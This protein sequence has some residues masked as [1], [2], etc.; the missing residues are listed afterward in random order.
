MSAAS[1]YNRVAGAPISWG[2]SE[3]PGWGTQL[4]PDRVLAEMR[5][6]GLRFVEAGPA[7]YLG[8][9]AAAVRSLLEE[10]GLS[11]VGGFVPAV[12]HDP[13]QLMRTLES[14][15]STAALYAAAGGR[16]LVSACVVDDD[17]SPRFDLDD[18]EWAALGEGLQR[19]DEIAAEHG[20]VHALHA[21]AGTLIESADDVDRILDAST[22]LLCIDTG[23]LALG[24]VDSARLVRQA[25]SRVAH[26]H[27]K[28]VRGEIAARLRNRELDF[29][30]AARRG[31]F[32][33][34]GDGEAPVAE[35][36]RAVERAGYTGWYVLEQDTALTDD[37]IPP[38]GTGPAEDVRRSIEF[39]RSVIGSGRNTPKEAFA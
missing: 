3:M 12:L 31:L 26:V 15:R 30:E 37:A 22:V 27:L 29:A 34:L 28:D 11:L 36:V 8:V 19:L 5:S 17:W 32:C 39:M 6:V 25:P 16:L 38:A 33:P 21:H 13:T 2:V 7:G 14:A 20:L 9:D 35:T 23:H 1:P 4:A 24:G 10:H 18:G